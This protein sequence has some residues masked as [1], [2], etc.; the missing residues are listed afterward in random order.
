[1]PRATVDWDN[2]FDE[3]HEEQQQCVPPPPRSLIGCGP[4]VSFTAPVAQSIR[5][6]DAPTASS[7]STQVFHALDRRHASM[8]GEQKLASSTGA[9]I[10]AESPQ[11]KSASVAAGQLLQAAAVALAGDTC[12]EGE[13]DQI[14]AAFTTSLSE[15]ASTSA[16]RLADS[17]QSTSPCRST[18]GVSPHRKAVPA[19]PSGSLKLA[20]QVQWI[21]E[22]CSLRRPA[23]KGTN[24]E[25]TPAETEE[26]KVRVRDAEVQHISAAC[27]NSPI[28]S[29]LADEGCAL[30]HSVAEQ[31][32]EQQIEDLQ[33][34]VEALSLDEGGCV[35]GKADTTSGEETTSCSKLDA[36]AESSSETEEEDGECSYMSSS[37]GNTSV[38]SSA[39]ASAMHE[40]AGAEGRDELPELPASYQ[41]GDSSHVDDLE[42]LALTRSE[43]REPPIP[44]Q[45]R[46]G[47][48]ALQP[49]GSCDRLEDIEQCAASQQHCCASESSLGNGFVSGSASPEPSSEQ[50]ADSSSDRM[51]QADPPPEEDCSQP[52]AQHALLLTMLSDLAAAVAKVDAAFESVDTSKPQAVTLDDEVPVPKLLPGREDSEPR[53]AESIIADVGL[54]EHMQGKRLASAAASAD[55]S[56][57]QGLVDTS[58]TTVGIGNNSESTVEVSEVRSSSSCSACRSSTPPLVGKPKAGRR[59]PLSSSSKAWPVAGNEPRHDSIHDHTAPVNLMP[60]FG[61]GMGSSRSMNAVSEQRL[62][63]LRERQAI[64]RQTWSGSVE[65]LTGLIREEDRQPQHDA[66]QLGAFKKRLQE[67]RSSHQFVSEGNSRTEAASMAT[68]AL[69]SQA[70][71]LADG[72]I[73]CK[74]CAARMQVLQGS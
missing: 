27:D 40:A 43:V 11:S 46:S 2:I 45:N 4:S 13:D 24:D 52:A 64:S 5:P 28:K 34:L 41:C 66:L 32:V 12:V 72:S 26:L 48:E 14:I 54:L 73:F 39:S 7:S 74:S 70:E 18:L 58:S 29:K 38:R 22:V 30:G 17:G 53:P 63:A 47:E 59:V 36:V 42:S 20:L 69:C 37:S 51:H 9:T 25:A 49:R 71:G 6:A 21:N 15:L 8:E 23:K 55:A 31:S 16:Q 68:C 1:M 35:K 3:L 33:G 65:R 50:L 19:R 67:R 56:L 57:G 61:S 62:S 44:D 10:K 60:S